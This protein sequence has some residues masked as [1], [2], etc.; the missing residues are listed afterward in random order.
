[1]ERFIIQECS[2]DGCTKRATHH[3]SGEFCQ[4]HGGRRLCKQDGCKNLAQQRGVC[5]RHGAPNYKKKTCSTEGCK[6]QSVRNGMCKRHGG[7][8]NAI[9]CSKEGCGHP[10]HSRKMCFHHARKKGHDDDGDGGNGM[11]DVVGQVVVCGVVGGGGGGDMMMMVGGDD[12]DRCR[13]RRRRRVDNDDNR[14]PP[15]PSYPQ[16]QKQPTMTARSTAPA[17]TVR[18]GTGR[19]LTTTTMATTP[20]LAASSSSSSS[21]PSTSD[22]RAVF[23]RR[24]PRDKIRAVAMAPST[25]TDAALPMLDGRP[26]TM[27]EMRWRKVGPPSSKSTTSRAAGG[28][29]GRKRR[30]L[31][32]YDDDH[33]V[34]RPPPS[35]PRCIGAGGDEFVEGD[36]MTTTTTAPFSLLG[37]GGGRR[38]WS[39][40]PSS[41]R[42]VSFRSSPSSSSSSCRGDFDSSRR[43]TS[44][45]VI[46][47]RD[48]LTI[49]N[50]SLSNVRIVN[51]C[52]RRAEIAEWY[53]P[54]ELATM[55]KD[56][57]EMIGGLTSSLSLYAPIID[58]RDR[59][60]AAQLLLSLSYAPGL[61]GLES[62]LE[63]QL[64]SFQEPQL[65]SL[66]E[67]QRESI[68]ETQRE[69]IRE[70]QCESIGE[71]QCESI[72]EAQLESFREPQQTASSTTANP[73]TAAPKTATLTT[74]TLTIDDK[75]NC[76]CYHNDDCSHRRCQR[77]EDND[78]S[79]RNNQLDLLAGIVASFEPSEAAASQSLSA[80]DR[81]GGRSSSSQR[82][83]GGWE[84]GSYN[85]AAAQ[86]SSSLS[87]TSSI[88]GCKSREGSD[89]HIPLKSKMTEISV[90]IK[91]QDQRKVQSA[92]AIIPPTNEHKKFSVKI[93][94]FLQ[95]NNLN[96]EVQEIFDYLFM[97]PSHHPLVA[98]PGISLSADAP[99]GV[100]HKLNIFRR[101]Y[102][103]QNFSESYTTKMKAG[104]KRT[105]YRSTYAT[106]SGAL[107][108][109][110]PIRYDKFGH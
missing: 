19:P 102:L 31:N 3:A 84:D 60:A 36:T 56:E 79:D 76:Y 91:V 72:G 44:S 32:A 47:G 46:D 38:N 89:Q 53:D 62:F 74:A 61:N 95:S 42:G 25:R 13:N 98:G 26:T 40:R 88:K 5:K 64:E 93:E 1:M 29:D 78:S 51:G 59:R 18:G 20:R 100:N 11:L 9:L 87:Y 86:S 22:A 35:H 52:D 94:N 101:S 92:K 69:P 39:G 49:T 85:H 45:G 41:S 17:A 110:T 108:T 14:S 80:R 73:T 77:Q 90:H 12:K 16:S 107:T 68:Q 82:G 103:R 15:P 21:R 37:I 28:D 10:V 63:P 54:E 43:P 109:G 55:E 8:N 97:H 106:G 96:Q 70:T 65:E 23:D 50:S 58:G 67:T 71:A 2:I 24:N 34:G 83:G 75:D 4:E 99:F 104:E 48:C 6:K 33:D 7:V 105:C 57:V 81:G 66:Q 27:E 30:R